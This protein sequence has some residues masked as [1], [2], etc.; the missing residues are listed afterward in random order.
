MAAAAAAATMPPAPSV[1][2]NFQRCVIPGRDATL[3]YLTCATAAKLVSA[4][5][6]L[7]W[8]DAS[9]VGIGMMAA[10]AQAIASAV[11]AGVSADWDAAALAAD[12]A[13]SELLAEFTPAA[14]SG[15]ADA[16]SMAKVFD[17]TYT[18]TSK[19]FDAQENALPSLP[20]PSPLELQ[21]G[22]LEVRTAFLQC[23]H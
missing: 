8:V 16:W 12:L 3:D 18:K 21:P 22:M 9:S 1:P 13:Q 4:V 11:A 20:T 2:H 5:P 17:R 15:F 7:G 19:L 23:L 14:L 6:S 10:P